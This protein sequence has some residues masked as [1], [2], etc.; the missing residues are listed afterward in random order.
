MGLRSDDRNDVANPFFSS[1]LR[2]IEDVAHNEQCLVLAGSTDG[3]PE[4]ERQLLDALVSRRVDGL[5]VVPT[6]A[7]T[8][9]L[10]SELRRGTPIVFLDLEPAELTVDLVRSDHFG[11]AVEATR[12][13]LA[14]GHQDIALF[15]DAGSVFSASQRVEGFRHALAE[16]GLSPA[17]ERIVTGHH[18]SAEWADIVEVHLTGPKP[19]TA[20]FT[21]QNFITIGAATTLHRLGLEHRVAHVGFDDVELADALSPGITVVPQDA[22][23]LGRRA[24]ELLF[25]RIAGSTAPPY[26]II[27]SRPLI[28]RGSGEIRRA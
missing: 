6:S 19:P 15:G 28:E 21:A 1:L 10:Q 11:G 22:S 14:H 16:A 4:R 24:A 23:E 2:G 13:L 5:I 3:E 25:T 7:D 27:I 9:S 26:K 8:S 17:P 18:T 12:H 20:L